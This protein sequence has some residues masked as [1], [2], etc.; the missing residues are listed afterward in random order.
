MIKNAIDEKH[1]IDS[2]TEYGGHAVRV[3]TK[4]VCLADVAAAVIHL[5]VATRQGN[6]VL[7]DPLRIADSL[8]EVVYVSAHDEQ[9]YLVFDLPV[10]TDVKPKTAPAAQLIRIPQRIV[11]TAVVLC[12]NIQVAITDVVDAIIGQ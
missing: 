4:I 7:A 11:E 3:K 1:L 5:P 8:V 9:R 6:A 2:L 12:S 10:R